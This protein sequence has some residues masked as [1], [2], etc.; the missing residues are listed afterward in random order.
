LNQ[1][2]RDI[3]CADFPAMMEPLV[4]YLKSEQLGLIQMPCPE[5]YVLGLGRDRTIPHVE[6]REGLESSAGRARLAGVIEGLIYQIKEYE[7]QDF[8][9]VGILGKNGS[10]SCG[11]EKTWGGDQV[12]PGEGAFINQLRTA[13]DHEEI[14]IG[15]KGVTDHRQEESIEWVK[16]RL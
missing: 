13:L 2:A 11:V 7:Y 16:T 15:I 9:I 14:K 8:Q 12:V 4:N 10:P 6:I 3:A 1:N 5:L